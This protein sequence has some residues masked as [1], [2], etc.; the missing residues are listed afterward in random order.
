MTRI[1]DLFSQI[2]DV[3]K[4]LYEFGAAEGAA[5]NLSVCVRGE[6]ELPG[7]FIERELIELPI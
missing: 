7:S 4:H 1:A 3:G 2:G 6:V 5:G